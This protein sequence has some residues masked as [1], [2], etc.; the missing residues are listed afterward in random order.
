MDKITCNGRR[1]NPLTPSFKW[2]LLFVA[3]FGIA[4]LGYAQSYVSSLFANGGNPPG[5]FSNETSDINSSGTE[6]ISAS[7][8]TNTWSA[9][10]SIPFTFNFNGS[11]VTHFRVS[12]NGLVSFDTTGA[13]GVPP[14]PNAALPASGLPDKTIAAFWD[15][16]TGSAPTG[17]NDRAYTLLLGSA[18]N[19][20]LVIKWYSYEWGPGGDFA[21][22]AVVLEE[23]T[24][25]IYIVE[26][27]TSSSLTGGSTT[28]GVQ[29]DGTTAYTDGSTISI[30]GKGS[31]PSDNSYYEYEF[32]PAGA[33]LPPS[34]LLTSNITSSSIQVDWT[35][36][37]GAGSNIEYGPQGFTL[38]TGT[39]L[40]VSGTSTVIT[41]LSANT[42]YDVYVRDSCGVSDFSSWSGPASA[43]TQCSP[44]TAPYSQNFDG[45][46]DP[47]I[48][49]CWSVLNASNNTSAW[50]ETENSSFDPQRSSPNAIEFY[51]SSAS[52]GLLLLVSPQFTDLDNTKQIRFFVQ[53]EGSSSYVSDLIVG[54]MTNPTDTSTFTPYDTIA[55]SQMSSNWLEVVIPFN[56]Y[57]GTD[58]YVAFAHGLNSTFDYIFMDDFSYEVIP[59]CPA[60]TLLTASNVT[61]SSADLGWTHASGATT[62]D[63]EYDTTGFTLGTGTTVSGVSN[64][65][66]L[67]GLSGN[68]S[69]DYYVRADCGTNGTSAWSGPYT[70]A[71]LCNPLVAPYAENF[72]GLPLTSPYT[73][74]PSCWEPQVGPDFWDVTDDATNT[75]HTYLPNIGDHTTGSSNYMWIDASSDITANEMVTPLIDISGLSSPY[76]GFWFASNNTNNSVNHT[77]SLDAWDGA[78]WVN[79][80]QTSGNF[81]GWVEVADTLPASIPDT[82][83]FRIQAIADPTGTSSTYYFNDLGVDDFFVKEQPSCTAPTTV[84]TSNITASSADV[85]WTSGGSSDAQ[86]Q[87]GTTGFAIGSGTTIAVAG[88]TTNISG[89]TSNTTYDVYVRDSCGTGN[90]SAW[91][92]PVTFSTLC[93]GPFTLPYTEDFNA[94]SG[95]FTVVNGGGGPE[96][97]FQTT[98]ATNLD[99]TGY[100]RV[101]SDQ[102]GNGVLMQETLLSPVI[103]AGSV[104]NTLVLEFDHYFNSIGGDS[105]A[106]DVYDGTN[107]VNVYAAVSDVGSFSTPD[108]QAIDITAYANANLQVRFYYDDGNT[109]AWYWAVDNFSLTEVKCLPQSLPYAENFDNDE[110]CFSIIDGLSDT[111]TWFHSTSASNLDGT[112][113]MRVDSDADGNGI[114]MQETLESPIID[115]GN[116][117][118][119]LTLEFDQYYRSIGGDSGA[120]DVFDGTNWVNVYATTSTVGAFS[121]PN[122]QTIDITAYAN[123]NLQVRFYY[124]DGNNWAWYWAVD[125]FSVRDIACAD[126]TALGATN[127]TTTSADLFWT[128]GGASN[129]NVEYGPAG[130][131]LGTGTQIS[132]TNDTISVS[133]L[134]ASTAYEFYVQDS[135][136][137]GNLSAFVGPFAFS[138]SV[139]DTSSAC[140]YT[141]DLFDSFGDGWNGTEVT[142][143]QNGTPVAVLGSNFTSGSTFGPVSFSLCDSLDAY[144]I[145]TTGGAGSPNWSEEIS[146][147]ITNPYATLA[148][149]FG[150]SS[151]IAQG[152]TLLTFQASCAAP[153]CAPVSGLGAFGMTT[154]S[155]E[156]FWTGVSGA[157]SYN[158]QYGPSGF[159]LGSGTTVSSTNDTLSLTSIAP[160][161]CYDFYVQTDCGSGDTSTYVGPFNF[162]TLCAPITNYPYTE[163]FATAPVT[164]LPACYATNSGSYSWYVDA[165]GTPSGATGPAVDHTFGN[166]TGNYVYTEA[167]S[168][169]S[170]GDTAILE[171]VEFDLTS[172]TTPEI[173]FWYHMY[174]A[175]IDTL[176]LQA[177]NTST[178]SWNTLHSIGGQQQPNNAA[179]WL[180]ARVDLSAYT[181]STALE[182]RFIT[183]RGSSFNGD[184]ALDDITVRETPACVDPTNL[185]ATGTTTS[186]VSL[187]WNSDTNIVAS[188]VQYGAPGFTFGTGTNVS[189]TTSGMGTVTGLMANTC[190]DFYVQDSCTAATGW[191]GPITVCTQAPCVAS[192]IPTNV[193]GD[194]TGCQGGSVALTATPTGNQRIVWSTGGQFVA[195]GSPYNTDSL[196]FTTTFEARNFSTSGGSIHLGPLP[197]IASA[198][199]GNFTNG[200]FITVLDTIVL[201][202]TTVRANGAV[203][204]QVIIAD[205][206]GTTIQQRGEVFTTPGG[207]TDNY[208]VP[209]GIVLTPGN[210]FIGVDFLTGTTGQLFRATGGAV[211]PY[212]APGLMSIDSVNFSGPRYYYTFDL[213]I[214][215][216]CIASGSA[217]AVAYVPG[218]NAGNSDTAL[219]CETDNMVNLAAFLGTHDAG[220]TWFDDDA[221][222]AL[223][224]SIFDATAVSATGMYNFSYVVP[225]VNNCAGD[226][227]TI[228]VDIEASPNAGNDATVN[229]CTTSAPIFL[230]T[231]L[232]VSAF[233]GTWT[234]LDSSGAFTASSSRLT[235]ANMTPGTYRFA[236]VIDG[237]ACPA[238]TAMVTVNVQTVVDAGADVIDTVCVDD[239]A[240]DLNTFL[241]AGATAGGTWIDAAATGS[242][243]GSIFDPTAVALNN[244]YTFTYL[245]NSACGDDSATVSLYVDDCDVSLPEL[246]ADWVTIYPNPTQNKVFIKASNASTAYDLEVISANG[247]LL[248]TK[249]FDNGNEMFIDLS[250]LAAG[251][252]SIKVRSE[253][254]YQLERIVKK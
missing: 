131:T 186:S 9:A 215:K 185:M 172:L 135:C 134:M 252:Y 240:V 217:T 180:E 152:D 20:Q 86:V 51:N 97:W 4:S 143:Y 5:A 254:G 39:Q 149:S 42:A 19:R 167:S 141:A 103:D 189:I 106:V 10:Q 225:G 72:D 132:A 223:T 16:F 193:M 44:Y 12:G 61:S 246:S 48:D 192:G 80:T 162:C 146:F 24:D 63:I 169:A 108:H 211:Y 182:L 66:T 160:S 241:S 142:V 156:L 208:Q 130:F 105:A 60:P 8:S 190:Y 168:P 155:A 251:V 138:T 124:D 100:M 136:G 118:G 82:T 140:S 14:S 197:S 194:T 46:T 27:Y 87:Y 45:T 227:A 183:Y 21:Y 153:A 220:G 73:D 95:C 199:F 28:V 3:V 181:T 170:A 96:S 116:I 221:T 184:V 49:A 224:D 113:Y 218:A 133:G 114:L 176:Y 1:G 117:L 200:Q 29:V 196:T 110:G 109:W 53:N 74:L 56:N 147:D 245:L 50:V 231:Y 234:D 229:R 101:D 247:Q 151:T 233:G 187:S 83:K 195:T 98:S 203:T 2:L 164:S 57:S 43:L 22:L 175:N 23:G 47:N 115:A 161:Q 250:E 150:G 158:V 88:T 40:S 173:V 69:Y 6:I 75:G 85:S 67:T 219:A 166:L 35:A 210:Y 68:T 90:V 174:G 71:T 112:G 253:N 58:Q 37:G 102:D 41:G 125:N 7:L 93:S 154:N 18:P 216:A 238:D 11:A 77:I 34:G 249:H 214:S 145:L 92:G 206:T 70:F 230:R 144:F 171:L 76:A 163:G 248:M 139:C 13:T 59:A 65:Y 177:Y 178:M 137:A 122:H 128:T 99:G 25:K 126:P 81:T 222:G 191:I 202:S 123:A 121:N 188:T 111:A 235:I 79:I 38:G 32:F 17:S 26:Q 159:A 104:T 242:L 107:W 15:D 212:V 54:T 120:V 64:P 148:G 62:Y 30:G 91:V 232:S 31:S 94:S 226:T 205:A 198:G 204:A 119:T 33:C 55:N 179:A 127:L 207:T 243:T 52:S 237:D 236:F 129:W 213:V 239:G 244:T 209:V 78:A 157:V 165:G 89:L 201:D 228:T 84:S 36:G